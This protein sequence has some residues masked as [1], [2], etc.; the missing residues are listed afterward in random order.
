VNRNDRW[1]VQ[2][3]AFGWRLYDRVDRAQVDCQVFAE[4]TA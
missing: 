4:E 2:N 3:D 1:F